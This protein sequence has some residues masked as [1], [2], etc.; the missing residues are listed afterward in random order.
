MPLETFDAVLRSSFISTKLL[1]Q[2][3]QISNDSPNHVSPINNDKKTTD[4]PIH[5]KENSQGK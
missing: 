3:S 5:K 1:D 2:N 4:N